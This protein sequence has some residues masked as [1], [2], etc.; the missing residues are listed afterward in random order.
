MSCTTASLSS[1]FVEWPA[2]ADAKR[3][4]CLDGGLLPSTMLMRLIALASAFFAWGLLGYF[5]GV[6]PGVSFFV[7]VAVGA[8][9]ML[10]ARPE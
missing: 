6:Y 1:G 7:G 3:E 4:A 9:A 8:G 2:R 5:T 10:A